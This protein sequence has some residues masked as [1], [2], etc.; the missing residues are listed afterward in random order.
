MHPDY[1]T[2]PS[3]MKNP[4][5]LFVFG[6]L[7]AIGFSEVFHRVETYLTGE[8]SKPTNIWALGFSIALTVGFLTC[9]QRR[10]QRKDATTRQPTDLA[11]PA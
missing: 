10:H 8:P 4:I 3:P 6:W 11:P 2:G 5:F 9:L 7:A 1:R